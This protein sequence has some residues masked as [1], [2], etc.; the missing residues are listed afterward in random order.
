MD[1]KRISFVAP[2]H[3]KETP[4]LGSLYI[5]FCKEHST[6]AAGGKPVFIWEARLKEPRWKS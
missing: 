5:H 2:I 6:W 4:L 3:S 1:K